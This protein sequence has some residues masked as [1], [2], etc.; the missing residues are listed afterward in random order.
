MSSLFRRIV[1]DC[2]LQSPSSYGTE[3]EAG[4]RRGSGS[5]TS[6]A[7]GDR[8]YPALPWELLHLRFTCRQGLVVES[9]CVDVTLIS[10]RIV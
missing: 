7:G 6:S 4:S 3:S 1:N 2:D 5:S 8:C 10:C 9:L